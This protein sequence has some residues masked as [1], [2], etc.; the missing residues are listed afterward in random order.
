LTQSLRALSSDSSPAFLAIGLKGVGKSAAFLYLKR[1]NNVDVVQ[2]I[3]AETQEAHEVAEMRAT[4]QYLPELRGEL[5]LQSLIAYLDIAKPRRVP[6]GL[7]AEVT[8]FVNDAWGHVQKAFGRLGGFTI[9]GVG[10]SFR[11]RD[12]QDAAFRLVPRNKYDKAEK[13]LLEPL[14]SKTALKK[15]LTK[16]PPFLVRSLV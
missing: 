10:I 4:L 14:L 16:G 15:G 1:P 7:H 2:A 5:I 12:K 9:L 13:L 11:A 3:S 8:A 6:T